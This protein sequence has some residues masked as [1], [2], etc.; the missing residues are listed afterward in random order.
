MSKSLARTAAGAIVKIGGW[1]DGDSRHALHLVDQAYSAPQASNRPKDYDR[2]TTSGLSLPSAFQSIPP[3]ARRIT[4]KACQYI[5]AS[6]G[7]DHA[8]PW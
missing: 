2:A 8:A 1:E 6:V 4:P 7:W 5:D 3:R